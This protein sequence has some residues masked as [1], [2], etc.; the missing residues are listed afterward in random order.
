MGAFQALFRAFGLDEEPAEVIHN[1]DD[2]SGDE[3]T[4]SRLNVVMKQDADFW[5]AQGVQIDYVA[6]GTSLE[7]AKTNF[8]EGLAETLLLHTQKFGSVEK[9]LKWAPVAAWESELHNEHYQV[10]FSAFDDA[11]SRLADLLPYNGVLY[12]TPQHSQQHQHAA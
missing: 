4:C 9:V 10:S 2:D 11:G 12:S 8:V 1:H 5:Y 7:E 3:V 6:Q